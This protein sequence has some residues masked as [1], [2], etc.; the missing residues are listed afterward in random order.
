MGKSCMFFHP[1]IH[2]HQ[3]FA[4]HKTQRNTYKLRCTLLHHIP[5]KQKV[6]PLTHIDITRGN[7]IKFS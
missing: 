1:K 7:M 6:A 5:Q 3:E 2:S 4:M